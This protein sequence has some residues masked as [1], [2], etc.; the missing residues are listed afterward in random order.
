[1]GGSGIGG[2]VIGESSVGDSCV[3]GDGEVGDGADGLSLASQLD[4]D[5][6][7][8]SNCE[9]LF[10]WWPL[11]ANSKLVTQSL[12]FLLRHKAVRNS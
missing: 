10:F 3:G 4:D 5:A 7:P 6:L 8:P 9:I 1:M 2:A 12:K 11:F